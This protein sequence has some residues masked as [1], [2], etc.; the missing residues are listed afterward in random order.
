M[1]T[2]AQ[3]NEAVSDL[4]LVDGL[5]KGRGVERFRDRMILAG[6]RDLQSYVPYYRSIPEEKAY[7]SSDLETV[8]N[9]YEIG[10][11]DYLGARIHD[12]IVRVMDED[13]PDTYYRPTHYSASLRHSIFDGG[14]KQ[15]SSGYT[16]KICFDR[17]K[18]Y[19]APLLK[20]NEVLKIL[21][22]VENNYKPLFESNAEERSA[23]T[24]LEDDAV[25]AV[26]YFVKYHFMK[27]VNDDAKGAQSN[28]S[29]YQKERR[30]LFSH[31]RDLAPISDPALTDQGGSFI[32][33]HG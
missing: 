19:S 26:H 1:K 13:E 11:F 29:Y 25:M 12:V 30:K 6:V 23:V 16:G 27:D 7:T 15:R 4:L 31:K 10:T 9:T 33:G 24:V 14:H 20:D 17:G 21:Y 32:V 5:R 8:E 18:F 28:L 3:F 22:S 2:W